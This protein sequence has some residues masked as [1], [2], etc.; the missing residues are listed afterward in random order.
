MSS[1]YC[2]LQQQG[3]LVWTGVERGGF[4]NLTGDAVVIGPGTACDPCPLLFTSE[5]V[6][7]VFL[8]L[9]WDATA[10]NGTMTVTIVEFYNNVW[11]LRFGVGQVLVNSATWNEQSESTGIL[12]YDPVCHTA[13]L[14]RNR[15][16][17]SSYQIGSHSLQPTTL[18]IRN[19]AI[20]CT[21]TI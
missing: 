16:G 19:A 7:P 1:L 15:N 17:S 11:N 21:A 20:G 6:N 13:I 10:N 4:T 2:A 18:A 14:N 5:F 3:V 9:C 12:Q 8:T